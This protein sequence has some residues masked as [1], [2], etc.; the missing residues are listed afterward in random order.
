MVV[1]RRGGAGGR[2]PDLSWGHGIGVVCRPGSEEIIRGKE[3]AVSIKIGCFSFVFHL[4]IEEGCDCIQRDR[5]YRL[6]R[7]T[8]EL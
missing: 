5:I 1:S 2:T 3:K 4:A 7:H 6:Y 8:I